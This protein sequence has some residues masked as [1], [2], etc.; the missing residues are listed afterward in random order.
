MNTATLPMK[1]FI[2]NMVCPRCIMT[3]ERILQEAGTP[4]AEVRLGEA[5]LAG[6]L[7]GEQLAGL[8]AALQQVGFE[9]LDDQKKLQMEKI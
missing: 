7:T 4:A 6:P 2:K 3:V 8:E 5:E 9:L 1:L